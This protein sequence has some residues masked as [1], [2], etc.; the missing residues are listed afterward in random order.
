[1]QLLCINEFIVIISLVTNKVHS[2]FLIGRR[3]LDILIPC[4]FMTAL[5]KIKEGEAAQH[6]VLIKKSTNFCKN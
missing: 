3:N 6:K 4:V 1:M 5:P 2:N